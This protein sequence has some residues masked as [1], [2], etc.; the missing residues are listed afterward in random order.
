MITG[1]RAQGLDATEAA[2]CGAWLHAQ[3][4][5]A[6]VEVAGDEAAVMATDVINCIGEVLAEIR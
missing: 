5:L 4:G 2:L 6:A 3:A 1:L